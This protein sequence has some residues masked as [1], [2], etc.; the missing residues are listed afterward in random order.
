MKTNKRKGIIATLISLIGLSLASLSFSFSWFMSANDHLDI[1]ETKGG[2][3]TQYFHCGDGSENN[4]FVI[5]RPVHLYNMTELY[6][7]LPGFATE[8]YHFQLGYDLEDNG[9]LEF[10]NYDDNGKIIED[11]YSDSLNMNY[12]ESLR[13]IGSEEKPFGGVFDG[14]N[15]TINNLNISGKGI[16]DIG[17]FGY[18]NENA[19]IKDLYIDNLEIDTAGSVNNAHSE[20][21]NA[22]VGYIAGH[23]DDAN[24]FSNTY[25]NNCEIKG[26]SVLTKND[27]GYF[28]KCENAASIEAFI[29]RANGQGEEEGQGGSFNSKKYNDWF[30]EQG[31]SNQFYNTYLGRNGYSSSG[32]NQKTVTGSGGYAINFST[33]STS[34]PETN[35][36][37]NRLRA[38]SYVPFK[39]EDDGKTRTAKSNTG[40]LVGSDLSG[41]NASPKISSYKM[42]NI[43]NAITNTAYASYSDGYKANG[44]VYD[45][46]KL[47]V[48]TYHNGSWVR[49]KDDYN[50]NNN[51]T[52]SKIRNYA[53][54]DNTTY[55]ALGFLKYKASRDFLGETLSEGSMIH[56]I[57]FDNNEISMSNLFTIP[58]GTARVNRIEYDTT[59]EVP[60]GSINFSMKERSI[61]NFFAGTYTSS[62]ITSMNFFSI[63]QVFRNGGDITNI[64]KI[65]AIYTDTT[66]AN[67][68]V[69]RYSDGSYSNGTRGELVFDVAAI[70]EGASPVNNMMYYFEVP[71]NAGEYA[72]GIAPGATQG[73]YM[74]YL[75]LA[76]NAGESEEDILIDDFKSV[77]YRSTP[78]IAENSILL[79][80][81]ELLGEQSLE[82][83][84]SFSGTTYTIVAN[85]D[86]DVIIYITTLSEDYSYYYNGVQLPSLIQTHTLS[87]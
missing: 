68:Y 43:G 35:H 21:N 61:I 64:K 28:G 5:T 73:A 25:V 60:K 72:M 67:N 4:P 83:S 81:Y 65:A 79:I 59:Y 75:D 24:C 53:K 15:L 77:E 6:D 40:Y 8:N 47:E 49:I 63:H 52:N 30:Y 22:Y 12:Y 14:S 76:A 2:I 82:I 32:F 46:N 51:S 71:V 86:N 37:V 29:N 50:A 27:W 54:N 44:V 34:S 16:S 84:V 62:N 69:Y 45:N 7:K 41:V 42:G 10:Y 74:I 38:G 80:T 48:L 20:H 1:K 39:F 26:Q 33:S 23:I 9:K 31:T 17:V 56:G 55:T 66:N 19:E 78:D 18:V 3:I 58:A 13:P 85:S 11:S 57:H 70:L 36:V 87:T